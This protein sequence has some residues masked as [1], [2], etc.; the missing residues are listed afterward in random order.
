MN[1]GKNPKKHNA[2]C[3][4]EEVIAGFEQSTLS[5]SQIVKKCLRIA[6]LLGDREAEIWFNLELMGYNHYTVGPDDTELFNSVI[7]KSGRSSGNGKYY[8]E[9]IP[10][11]E[12]MVDIY[13]KQLETVVYPSGL[14]EQSSNPNQ[15]FTG[16]QTTVMH[17]SFA[18]NEALN[19][20]KSRQPLLNKVSS[21]IYKWAASTYYSLLFGDIAENIF[22]EARTIVETELPKLSKDVS[23]SLVS[24][25][26]RFLSKNSEEWSQGLTSCRRALRGLADV[27]YPAQR[28]PSDD[29]HDLS[30]DK[31][32][33]RL[34]EFVKLSKISREQRDVVEKQ[35]K[36]IGDRIATLNDLA[37]KGVHSSVEQ[38]EAK[39]CLIH[40]YLLFAELL[41]LNREKDKGAIQ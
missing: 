36:Y 31:Y 11:M 32:E 35:I 9:S 37:S 30:N 28:E 20:L 22:H 4:C 8:V 26:D 16:L 2:I 3:I 12:S 25:N 15:L 19:Y 10:D 34:I 5:L 1:E 21:S 41:K 23:Q 27:L 40:M 14:A 38:A 7:S 29:G 13:K 6:R 17:V 39:L 18:R 24:A 33:N